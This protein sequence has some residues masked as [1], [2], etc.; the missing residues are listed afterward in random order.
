MSL[1]GQGVN[2]NFRR[3]FPLTEGLFSCIYEL[4]DVTIRLQNWYGHFAIV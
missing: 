1:N 4:M 3:D 2:N